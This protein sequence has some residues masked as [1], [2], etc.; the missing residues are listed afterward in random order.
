M[1]HSVMA[2]RRPERKRG[3]SSCSPAKTKVTR[4]AM[5]PKFCDALDCTLCARLKK[6]ET[7]C[8]EELADQHRKQVVIRHVQQGGA[9]HSPAEVNISRRAPRL[10][11]NWGRQPPRSHSKTVL[12]TL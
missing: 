5:A 10:N 2:L 6:P 9:E 7:R 3:K 1:R 4:L 11:S 8:G 12:T